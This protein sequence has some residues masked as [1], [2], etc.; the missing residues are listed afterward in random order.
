MAACSEGALEIEIVDIAAW[1]AR[2]GGPPAAGVPVQDHSISTTRLTIPEGF[3]PA[4][5][6]HSLTHLAPEEPHWPLVVMTVLTQLSVGAIATIWLLHVFGAPTGL[7][8]AAVASLMAGH[9]ALGA[10]TLHLSR[11]LR[12]PR[13]ENGGARG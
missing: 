3:P 6:A 11:R 4:V 13:A 9:L 8:V 7:G 2:Y 12:I 10:A 5:R 1:R